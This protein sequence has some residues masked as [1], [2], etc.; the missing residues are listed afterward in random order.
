MQGCNIL[1]LAKLLNKAEEVAKNHTLPK[2]AEP[3][4]EIGYIPFSGWLF[5]D[6]LH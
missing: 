6:V 5:K 1:N 3:Q 4:I 2:T